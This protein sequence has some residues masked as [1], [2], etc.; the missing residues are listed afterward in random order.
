[1][2]LWSIRLP[3]ILL[4]STDYY[5]EKQL[6]AKLFFL[7]LT[8]AMISFKGVSSIH[9]THFLGSVWNQTSFPGLQKAPWHPVMCPGMKYTN[10]HRLPHTV[11]FSVSGVPWPAHNSA[12]DSAVTYSWVENS[13]PFRFPTMAKSIWKSWEANHLLNLPVCQVWP[14]CQFIEEKCCMITTVISAAGKFPVVRSFTTGAM[15]KVIKRGCFE[16]YKVTYVREWVY[17][18]AHPG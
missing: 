5:Y 9:L 11:G 3:Q 4:N 13:R 2:V 1:M 10:T 14:R 8:A 16:G 6:R 7:Y 18:R 15:N 12:R 17:T